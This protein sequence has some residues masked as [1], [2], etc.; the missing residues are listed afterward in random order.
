MKKIFFLGPLPIKLT[1]FQ[2][3]FFGGDARFQFF[4][5]SKT[6]HIFVLWTKNDWKNSKQ[7]TFSCG[8]PLIVNL[9]DLQNVAYMMARKIDI[10]CFLPVLDSSIGDFVSKLTN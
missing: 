7:T 5:V 8:E 9:K 6:C 10:G 4:S 3:L 2:Y 1:R